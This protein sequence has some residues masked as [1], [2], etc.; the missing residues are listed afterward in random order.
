[1]HDSTSVEPS[2]F[3]VNID[4]SKTC[5]AGA[6]INFELTGFTVSGQIVSDSRC[7]SGATGVSG[8]S[9]TL[10]SQSGKGSSQMI[11]SDSNGKYSFKNVVPGKYFVEA[12]HPTW[13]F[14]QNKVSVEVSWGATTVSDKIIVAG[15]DLSGRVVIEGNDGIENVDIILYTKDKSIS[16]A[17][18]DDLARVSKLPHDVKNIGSAVCVT[19]S[20]HSGKFSFAGLPC[21]AYTVVPVYKP[22]YERHVI[23][24]G[25]I[26]FL[27]SLGG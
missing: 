5:N 25:F 13:H 15:F 6:D 9:V 2:E 3:A 18:C 1:M 27:T 12:S 23:L 14:S 8:I 24:F 22:A 19:K 10:R 17:G 4:D 16:V 11:K 26:S 21:G 7:K 20:D